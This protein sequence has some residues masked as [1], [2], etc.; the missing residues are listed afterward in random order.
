MKVLL[1]DDDQAI[2]TVFET[3]LKKEGFEVITALDGKT[4]LEKAKIERPNLILLDQILPDM[5]GNDLLKTLKQDLITQ[6]IPVAILSNFGQN[7]LVQEAINAG[8][9]DYILK[10]QIETNDLM[11]KVKEILKPKSEQPIAPNE[12]S[13]TL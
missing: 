12:T 13:S 4:G 11:E 9:I 2:L 6:K 3:A 8:A 1:I 5:K 10:Y 7:E